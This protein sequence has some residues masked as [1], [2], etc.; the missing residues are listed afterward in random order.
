MAFPNLIGMKFSMLTV[1]EKS[2]CNKHGATV[3]RCQCDCGAETKLATG[4]LKGH[5]TKSCGCLRRSSPH[6]TRHGMSETP[7]HGAYMRMRTRCRSKTHK[8]YPTYG[9]RG[10]KARYKSFEE[11]FADLG[12][13]PGPDY[14]VDRIDVN[15]HYE[16]GNC[17][18]A[19]RREQGNNRRCNI[20]L[21]FNG[22][23][24]GIADW[25]REIGIR[26]KALRHRITSYGWPVERALTEPARKWP[27][28]VRP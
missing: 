18:W 5:H 17:R 22:R 7:E 11:F 27:S 2:H 4:L 13:R 3:W 1:I 14:S 15:G 10:I 23:T 9:G 19:T 12:P 25:A 6:R 16:P 28:Q 26:P 8:D 21:T 24:Q 20:R